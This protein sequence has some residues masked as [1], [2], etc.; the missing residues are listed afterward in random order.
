[1]N[2]NRQMDDMNPCTRPGIKSGQVKNVVVNYLRAHPE[3]RQASA[4]ALAVLPL[5]RPGARPNNRRD[6]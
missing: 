6:R 3:K 2:M 4:A 1:M 5:A